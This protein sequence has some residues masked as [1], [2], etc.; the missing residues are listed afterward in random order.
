MVHTA[1]AKLYCKVIIH[2]QYNNRHFCFGSMLTWLV[3]RTVISAGLH[4]SSYHDSMVGSEV[5][6][7]GSSLQ[8]P[9]L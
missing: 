9:G 4:S 1:R 5:L 3:E 7:L 8:F 6:Q 2:Q